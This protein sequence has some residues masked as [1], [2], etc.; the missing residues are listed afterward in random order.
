MPDE[1][2][3]VIKQEVQGDALDKTLQQTKDIQEAMANP[4]PV[5][6]PPSGSSSAPPPANSSQ[7]HSTTNESSGETE[8]TNQSKNNSV[9]KAR[10]KFLANAMNFASNLAG[11]GPGTDPLGEMSGMAPVTNVISAV[12]SMF[13]PEGQAVATLVNTGIDVAAMVGNRGHV[14]EMEN[15]EAENNRQR[16][17]RMFEKLEGPDG[18]S[19]QARAI[20]E[21]EKDNQVQIKAEQAKFDKESELSL[22]RPSTWFG[23]MSNQT[24]AKKKELQDKLTESQANQA[25]AEEEQN[26]LAERTLRPQMAIDQSRAAGKLQDARKLENALAEA[27]EDRRLADEGIDDPAERKK[28]AHAKVA[29]AE[30]QRSGQFSHLVTGRTSATGAAK[31]ATLA[32]KQFMASTGHHSGGN[33]VNVVEAI[34]RMHET[35]QTS[36]RM[37]QSAYL[38]PFSRK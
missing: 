22:F 3:V 38:K 15:V 8:G 30:L 33:G 1:I 18:T 29:A 36:Q 6:P 5:R 24:A 37:S 11:G 19:R 7:S 16:D 26:K 2:K 23:A 17:A 21:A 35:V 34:N 4:P 32:E 27:N 28:A 31:L 14:M 9:E 25:H 20:A 13:G 10:R 12:G